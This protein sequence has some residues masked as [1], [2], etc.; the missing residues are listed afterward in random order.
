MKRGRGGWGLVLWLAPALVAGLLA[1]LM[2]RPTRLRCEA[3]LDLDP[4]VDAL[5]AV[6]EPYTLA[7]RS[8]MVP[9]GTILPRTLTNRFPG[10]AALSE[11][12]LRILR[13]GFMTEFDFVTFFEKHAVQKLLDP[14]GRGSWPEGWRW[15]VSIARADMTDLFVAQGKVVALR[16]LLLAAE[17]HAAQERLL[18]AWNLVVDY[19]RDRGRVAVMALTL[20]RIQSFLQVA[21]GISVWQASQP[22]PEEDRQRWLAMR[23]VITERLD[24]VRSLRNHLF[25]GRW[26]EQRQAT[27]GSLAEQDERALRRLWEDLPRLL[28]FPRQPEVGPVRLNTASVLLLLPLF[29]VL[30]GLLV[31]L[32]LLHSTSPRQGTE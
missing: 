9:E 30:L 2:L 6:S 25:Q 32:R 26:P 21:E 15:R 22:C 5:A 14:P 11:R 3:V 13:Y 19:L 7:C 18:T 27:P 1:F 28:T 10:Y 17:G 31:H 8:L 20:E 12:G 24:L 29:L 4:L 23:G 16:S